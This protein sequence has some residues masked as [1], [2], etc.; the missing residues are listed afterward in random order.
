MKNKIT[1]HFVIMVFAAVLCTSQLFVSAQEP[2]PALTSIV[3]DNASVDGGFNPDKHEFGLTLV[4]NT[5]TPT[6]KNY[7]IDGDANIFVNYIYDATHHSTGIEVRLEYSSGSSIYDFNYTNPAEY[8]ANDNNMLKSV[9]CQ[10]GELMPE[11]NEKDTVYKLY[12]PSDLTKLDITPVTADINAHCTSVELKL[13]DNQEPTI[14]LI[15]TASD[16]ESTKEY[17]LKIKR[18]DKTIH[19]IDI[20]RAQPDYTSFVEGTR[21]YERPEVIITACAVV[22]GVITLLVLFRITRRIAVNPY[23][24]EEKPFYS[25][26]E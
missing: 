1:L 13:K 18:V 20:E 3:F 7:Q 8:E 5:V 25:P 15:C 26:V 10:Y 22:G 24:K 2:T 21:F 19:E 17:S 14:T 9:Y 23:D 11:M 12:I 6:L 4:D 16:G